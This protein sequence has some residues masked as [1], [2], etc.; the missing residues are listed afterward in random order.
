MVAL[1]HWVNEADRFTAD[2]RSLSVYFRIDVGRIRRAMKIRSMKIF[3][4]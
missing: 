4:W 3:L 2:L 1:R